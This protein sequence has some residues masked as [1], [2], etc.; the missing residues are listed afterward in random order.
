MPEIYT[1][2][3]PKDTSLTLH[4]VSVVKESM[5]RVYRSKRVDFWRWLV[6]SVVTVDVADAN[7]ATID[8]EN[9]VFAGAAAWLSSQNVLAVTI[10]RITFRF[11]DEL[12]EDLRMRTE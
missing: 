6:T 3:K 10:E 11:E 1:N 5:S 2:A 8:Y 9:V 7:S 4:T 12:I